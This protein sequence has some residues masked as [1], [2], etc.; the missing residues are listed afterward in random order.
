MFG[1][2]WLGGTFWWLF[3]SMHTYGGLA[4]PLAIAA[5]LALAGFLGGYYAVVAWCFKRLAR[6]PDA[7]STMVFAAIWTL[8]ELARGWPSITKRKEPL[9]EADE[10]KDKTG[11]L[12]QLIR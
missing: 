4:A 3:I 10:W 2:A 5:V 8:A 12:D 6:T 1:T 9:P 11:K 7:M